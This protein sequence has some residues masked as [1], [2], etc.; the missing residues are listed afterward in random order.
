MITL[1]LNFCI[2]LILGTLLTFVVRGQISKYNIGQAV[3]EDGPESHIEKTDTPTMGG[4]AIICAFAVLLAASSAY[5]LRFSVRSVLVLIVTVGFALVGLIDDLQKAATGDSTGWR[6][7]YKIVLEVL[8]A[9][10]FMLAVIW[11]DSFI[12]G[13]GATRWHT[14]MLWL[15]APLGVF[16]IVGAANS[17]NFTD[18]LDGLAAGLTTICAVGL[19]GVLLLRGDPEMALASAILA[20]AAAGFVWFNAHPASIFMGDVGSLGL[21]AA[22]GCIA[23]A[24]AVEIIF[25][26]IA[27]VFIWETLSVIIQVV[28]FQRFGRRV[29]KMSPFHHHLELCGWEEPTIVIR[30]WLVGLIL[31]SIGWLVARFV[32]V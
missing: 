26:V 19:A 12:L 2:A 7:R 1:V 5:E 24:G 23:V 30:L 6:A 17:V 21:G 32:F 11:E 31:A 14:G 27:A 13:I 25:A 29:F 9:S 22:L 18:G 8:L 16:V 10:L 28:S 15:W 3:R 20:G 4:I